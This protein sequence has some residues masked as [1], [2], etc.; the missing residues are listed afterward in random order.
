M[1]YIL[2]DYRI[3]GDFVEEERFTKRVPLRGLVHL[4]SLSYLAVLLFMVINQRGFIE[5]II[6]K[7]FRITVSNVLTFFSSEDWQTA[8]SVKLNQVVTNL[9]ILVIIQSIIVFVG[10]A[11]IGYFLWQLRKNDQWHLSEKLVVVGYLF[12]VIAL[13][14]LL[15]KMAMETY[16]TY[17]VI[18]GRIHRLSLEELNRFH[19][20][21]SDIFQHST[22]TLDQMIP[23]VISLVEQ[24]KALIQTTRNI[25]EIPDLVQQTWEQLLV[26]KNWLVGLSSTAIVIILGGHMIEGLRLL[27]NSQW[28]ESKLQRTKKNR[29]I[30]VNERLVEVLEQQQQ[31]IELLSKGQSKE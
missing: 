11:L 15:T 17:T 25:A 16:Q 28:A 7:S 24:L 13:L 14:T 2:F 3:E 9:T 22:F 10:L 20:K 5:N 19:Q 29:Q 8:F 26:L 30:E 18:E 6:R 21:L 23:S 1:I 31:L 27:K 12:L 4:S